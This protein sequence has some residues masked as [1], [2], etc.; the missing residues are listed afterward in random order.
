MTAACL[1]AWFKTICAGNDFHFAHWLSA[2]E[3]LYDGGVLG[4]PLVIPGPGA[5]PFAADDTVLAMNVAGRKLPMKGCHDGTVGSDC[6]I[7]FE[8]CIRIDADR[9]TDSVT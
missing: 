5:P 1:T 2:V 7:A 8:R 6:C 3:Y 4:A 9:S